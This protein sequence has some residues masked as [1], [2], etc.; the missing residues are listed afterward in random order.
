M[1]APLEAQLS[2]KVGR[3]VLEKSCGNVFDG[4]GVERLAGNQLRRS[5]DRRPDSG[6]SI[7]A[8]GKFISG[9]SKTMVGKKETALMCVWWISDRWEGCKKRKR[10]SNGRPSWIRG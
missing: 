3:L 4:G 8:D 1:T 9:S 2:G 7:I 6:V 10:T 5:T